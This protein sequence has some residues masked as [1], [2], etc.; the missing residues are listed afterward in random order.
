MEYDYK[1]AESNLLAKYKKERETIE[2]VHQSKLDNLARM[3]ERSLI[4]MQSRKKLMEAK[5]SKLKA[6]QTNR[7]QSSSTN[8]KPVIQN[9][10]NTVMNELIA[11]PKLKL[12]PM[13]IKNRVATSLSSKTKT[14]S[15][16]SDSAIM[17]KKSKSALSSSLLG[18]KSS[19]T[20][21]Q[22]STSRHDYR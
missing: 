22:R 1:L 2:K 11:Q 9:F 19:T 17:N 3:K 5:S 12:P 10:D 15:R 6:L 18:F 20:N 16:K 13:K 8:S 7:I 4:P 21:V 14:M